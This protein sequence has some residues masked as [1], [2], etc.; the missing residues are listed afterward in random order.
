MPPP[1]YGGLRFTHLP[2]WL[3]FVSLAVEVLCFVRSPDAHVSL[4]QDLRR[5]KESP[6]RG[7]LCRV[8]TRR[9][10]LGA[11]CEGPLRAHAAHPVGL[12]WLP[13]LRLFW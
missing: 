5:L 10:P 9:H 6:C 2:C 7:W 13:L 11:P 4:T 1:K 3:V 8:R 12:T